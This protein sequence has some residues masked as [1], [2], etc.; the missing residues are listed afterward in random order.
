MLRINGQKRAMSLQVT[1]GLTVTILPD[2]AHCFLMPT[3]QVAF[4]YGVTDQTIRMMKNNHPDEF[5]EGK[6]YLRRVR[7]IDAGINNTLTDWTKRGIIRLGF[8]IKSDRARLFRDWAEDLVINQMENIR[9]KQ[10]PTNAETRK[11]F[12]ALIDLINSASVLC[13]SHNRLAVRLGISASIFSHVVT[14]PWL[15]SENMLRAIETGCKNIITR[16]NKVDSEALEA[17]IN[18][19][20]KDSRIVLYKKLK[21]GGML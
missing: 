19:D 8:F 13:G 16:G 9:K 17:L 15:V 10:L 1:E 11:E 4:G 6:H 14:R 20:D 21:K 7:F 12:Q 5:I 18:I 3:K 2:S